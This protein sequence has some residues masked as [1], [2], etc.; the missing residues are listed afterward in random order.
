MEKLGVDRKMKDRNGINVVEH[1]V[2]KDE[3][4][5]MNNRTNSIKKAY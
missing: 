4:V 5:I 3:G 1:S 2:S